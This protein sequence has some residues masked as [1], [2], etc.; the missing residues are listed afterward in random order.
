MKPI[1]GPELVKLIKADTRLSNLRTI[2]IT[3]L[4]TKHDEAWLD[5]ADGYVAKPFGLAALIDKIEEVFS[6]PVAAELA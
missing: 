3:P 6:R 5:G 4:Q 1:C 2:L